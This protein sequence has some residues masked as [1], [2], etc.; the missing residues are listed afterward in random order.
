MDP[1]VGEI[2]M[3]GFNFA[4]S[5][6]AFCDG[7]L[8]AISQ[9]QALF[10]L[11]GTTFGG[12]GVSN[13]QLPDMR[14]RSPVGMG[15]GPGLTTVVQGEMSGVEQVT[16]LV[17]QMPPHTHLGSASIAIPATTADGATP[18]PTNASILG[19]VTDPAGSGAPAS[20]YATTPATTTLQP[21]STTVTNQLAG[22]GQ[23][24]PLRNPYLGTNFIIAMNGVFPSRP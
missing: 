3:V 18:T 10:A 13:F 15:T 8:M 21:F 24:V 12:N 16:L 2:K 1:F 22:G 14:G 4:P 11:L 6:Y 23:P 19:G 17:T 20:L 5:G 7:S 9:N